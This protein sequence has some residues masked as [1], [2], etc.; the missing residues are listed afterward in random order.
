MLLRFLCL[1][2]TFISEGIEVLTEAMY[3]DIL[4][5][6]DG[7]EHARRAA[8]HG[9]VLAREFDATAHVVNVVDIQAAGGPFD[10]GGVGKE[11]V[12]RLESE[13][14]KSIEEIREILSDVPIQ[15][16]ILRG[17]PSEE[18]LVYAEKNDVDLIA[19]GTHG[20]KG[21]NRY[22]GSVARR[23]LRAADAPVLT[24][25]ATED[26]RTPD[27]YDDVLVPTDGSE[28]AAEAIDHGVAIAEKSGG[29]VHTVNVADTGGITAALG[30]SR[31]EKLREK[32]KA[33][34]EKAV[35]E[36]AAKAEKAGLETATAV[37]EGSPS[38]TLLSYAE[39]HGIDL[40]AMST[41]GRTGIGEHLLGST[42][43]RVIRRAETPVLAVGT[44]SRS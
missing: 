43:E 31:K 10:A 35:K 11:F 28:A 23:V 4:L 6:T 7:S 40:I 38:K 32:L 15:T 12:N 8:E 14:E 13:G 27:S 33:E 44:G 41:T 24:V 34:G 37:V 26:S 29:R 42:A 22:T 1:S 16:K 17:T 21:V 25:R 30:S 20:R 39:K 2:H 5:T 18:I 36:V 3:D 19:M 9:A